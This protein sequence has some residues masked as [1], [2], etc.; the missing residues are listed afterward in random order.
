MRSEGSIEPESMVAL[1]VRNG[2]TFRWATP[3]AL[4]GTHRFQGLQSF[5]DLYLKDAKVCRY[6][7]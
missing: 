5:F 6:Q 2:V 3:D 1:A 7:S 4:R